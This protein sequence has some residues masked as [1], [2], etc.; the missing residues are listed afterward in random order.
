[1]AAESVKNELR[2]ETR[3]LISDV[4]SMTSDALR[5]S[6]RN[7]GKQE[8]LYIG[9]HTSSRLETVQGEPLDQ[10]VSNLH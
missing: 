6:S 4:L 2:S 8:H 5:A 9:K 7:I 10:F 3:L 1:M